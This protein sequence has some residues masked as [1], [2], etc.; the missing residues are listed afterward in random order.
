[1]TTYHVLYETTAS[2][3]VQVDIDDADMTPEQ[4]HQA[5]RDEAWEVYDKQAPGSLCHH[6]AS[7]IQVGEEF[8]QSEAD[9]A[10]WAD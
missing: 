7:K 8:E 9:G 2:F 6:C 1:M 3:T 4:A 10:V 5:A